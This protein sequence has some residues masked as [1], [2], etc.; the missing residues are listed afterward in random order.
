[1]VLP[2]TRGRQA[3]RIGPAAA[4]ALLLALAGCMGGAQATRSPVQPGDP[5]VAEAPQLDRK[6]AVV[7][8]LIAELAGRQSVLPAGGPYA[9]IA[10]EVLA[11]GKASAEAELRVKRLTAQARSR[12]WL[13]KLGPDVSLSSLGAIAA[14]LVLDQAILDNG[15]RKAERD[16]AAADVEVA[17]VTL[18]ADLNA[19]VH[20]GLKLY[21]EAQRA[22]EL[23][24]ITGTALAEMAE[25]E[26]IMRIRVEGGL[27]DGS[28]QR[29]LAQKVAE[30]EA[31]LASERQGE[32]RAWAE[33]AVLAGRPMEGLSGLSALPPDPGTPE[34]LSVLMARAEAAR[35]AAE[36]RLARSGLMP[37]F[38]A[39]AG[40]SADG[41]LDAGL[42]LDGEGL[43][44][45][46]K[47]GLKA[48]E[49]M[50]EVARRKVDEAELSAERRIVAL[51]QEI[52]AL[53]ARQAQD[54]KVLAGM[55]GNLEL[56]TEQYRAGRRSLLELVG[57]FE[58]LARARRDL[59]T[60]KYQIAVARLEI[61]RERGVLVDGAA[62]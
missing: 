18:A 40:I 15:R 44:F 60:I 41:S 10:Q 31:T 47:A 38:G 2:G 28:E 13:P 5:A 14:Q 62:L 27:S 19:R 6:G 4:A 29:V 61:A 12:N 54:G 20:D 33:L 51:E 16:F 22:R 24:A 46:R 48:I 8:S 26:R 52:A 23:A 59:A 37:G 32:A 42:A 30:M 50:E 1:M 43:G 55:E 21:I 17:A 36:A 45:G 34:A 11:T 7:S 57:Q 58:S 9:Q 35:M 3:G 25:F 39:K 49:E 56:F 53:A